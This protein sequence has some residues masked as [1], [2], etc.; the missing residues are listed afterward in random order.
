MGPLASEWTDHCGTV[1]AGVG[2]GGDCHALTLVRANSAHPSTY[3]WSMDEAKW[4]GPGV[5]ALLHGECACHCC[6]N[7]DVWC[8]ESSLRER[9]SGCDCCG[10]IRMCAWAT[11]GV[12]VTSPVLWRFS[13]ALQA[14][15]A[16]VVEQERRGRLSGVSAIAA[17]TPLLALP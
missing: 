12:H 11:A 13:M 7:A 4:G 6:K 5:W 10:T 3:S 15:C 2:A 9:G 16:A 14:S 8:G 1:Y 17:P